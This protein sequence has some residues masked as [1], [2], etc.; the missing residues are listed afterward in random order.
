[1]RLE[2]YKGFALFFPSNSEII[3]GEPY[4]RWSLTKPEFKHIELKD[5][6]ITVGFG[7]KFSTH[8][9][10]TSD[11]FPCSV[12]VGFRLE[13]KRDAS[14]LAKATELFSTSKNIETTITTKDFTEL[15]NGDIESAVEETIR[16]MS[17]TNIFP[18]INLKQV[19]KEITKETISVENLEKEIIKTAKERIESKGFSLIG[20]NLVDFNLSEPTSDV[21]LGINEELRER[22]EKYLDLKN[23][24]TL[25][26]TARENALEEA[27]TKED[28]RKKLAQEKENMDFEVKKKAN[29]NE[30]NNELRKLARLDKDEELKQKKALTDIAIQI[31]GEDD[32]IQSQKIIFESERKKLEN[33]EDFKRE[34]A[35]LEQDYDLDKL[36][37]QE[38]TKKA[39]DEIQHE[40]DNEEL[41]GLKIETATKRKEIEV[42][43]LEYFKKKGIIEAE[44]EKLKKEAENAA[45]LEMRKLLMQAMPEIMEKAYKPV[46]RLGEVKLMYF[47]GNGSILDSEDI[48]HG[49]NSL[50]SIIS[51][52]SI[53]P[54]IKELLK[55]LNDWENTSISENAKQNK[56]EKDNKAVVDINTIS[57]AKKDNK[58]KK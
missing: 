38:E 20:C 10:K 26:S 13:V 17:Y 41:V 49:N 2:P 58:D 15:L 25:K 8:P 31:S 12:E 7:S 30:T 9:A 36:R 46:E 43:E 47:G 3:I 4:N 45:N 32:K 23:A 50:S 28:N 54:M 37:R 6:K 18:S 29:E 52:F 22:W 35:K 44:I 5:F 27:K 39:K 24:I 51:S 19:Q 16:K 11:N 21:L 55:F 53:F 48:R 57:E 42:I 34:K 33:D 56:L 40:K 14:N 1:M